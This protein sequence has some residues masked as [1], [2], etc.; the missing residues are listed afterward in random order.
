MRQNPGFSTI[1]QWFKDALLQKNGVVKHY[2]DDSTETLKEEYKNLTEEEFMALLMDD[3]VDVKEHTEI[4]D[5]E[6]VPPLHDVV[7]NRTYEDGQVRIE[8]VPP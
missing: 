1:Y 5:K 4:M 6:G 8:P 7:V 3:N 2:W